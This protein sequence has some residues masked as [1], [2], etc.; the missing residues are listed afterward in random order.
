MVQQR[1]D[2]DD[3]RYLAADEG[4]DE[5]FPAH[6]IA[7]LSKF[8]VAPDK[9]AEDGAVGVVE[10][11]L[12]PT[13][14]CGTGEADAV[15]IG[16]VGEARQP[17]VGNMPV[18]Y[19]DVV[20]RQPRSQQTF[21]NRRHHRRTR[22]AVRTGR[23]EDLDTN[24]VLRGNEAAPSVRDGGLPS[25]IRDRAVGHEADLLK[26]RPEGNG[27]LGVLRDGDKGARGAAVR[28]ERLRGLRREERETEEANGQGAD[29]RGAETGR[30]GDSLRAVWAAPDQNGSNLEPG[31]WKQ[32]FPR[33]PWVAASFGSSGNG[34]FLDT[35]G[36]GCYHH[37]RC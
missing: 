31:S 30:P 34:A 17:Q 15:A 21:D 14:L 23:R 18:P 36:R 13:G 8:Q 27:G 11:F 7:L 2:V 10:S 12:V 33:I 29:S 1:G 6:A 4:R 19:D 20:G 28:G 22:A 25:E 16:K 26:V 9:I 37:R 32:C 24:D 5:G 3:L 35:Y